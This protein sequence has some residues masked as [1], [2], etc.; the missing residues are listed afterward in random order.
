MQKLHLFQ[1]VCVAAD[2]VTLSENDLLIDD[3]RI[4]LYLSSQKKLRNL[5]WAYPNL[6]QDYLT[7]L[8]FFLFFIKYI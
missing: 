7:V 8:I 4:S 3:A 1:E 5:S 2:H 6:R